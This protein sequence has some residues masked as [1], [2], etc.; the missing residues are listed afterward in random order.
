MTKYT[1]L[2]PAYK[3]QYLKESLTSI[4][5]Q[6]YKEFDVLISDDCSPENLLEV[7]NQFSD[8]RI[9]Y[10]RNDRNI[11]AEQLVKHWNLLL[12]ETESEYIIMASDDDIYETDF[13]EKIDKL[14][15]KYPQVDLLRARI[16]QINEIEEPIFEDKLYPEYQNELEATLSCPDLCVPNYV[17]KRIELIKSGGFIDFPYA[18]GSDTATAIMMS[19]NGLITT[20]NILFNYRISDT[21]ISHASKNKI[22]DKGK[23]EAAI[24]FHKWLYTHIK[25]L[26]YEK[27]L[28]NQN[29]VESYIKEKISNG[30]KH[31]ARSYYGAL[32]FKELKSLYKTMN[33]LNCF[34]RNYDRLLFIIDY[35]KNKKLYKS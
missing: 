32:N 2:L 7:V 34:N 11:G 35:F 6:S 21:Q 26:N 29:K 5:H 9:K 27:T 8:S 23:M 15:I 20:S 33:S 25:N 3:S 19:K 18:M 14:A 30:I 17:F 22:I 13:L 24:Q 1:F 4:I 10:R 31:C 12:R 16:R 28:L